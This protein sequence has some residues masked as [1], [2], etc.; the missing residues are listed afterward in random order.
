MDPVFDL[1]VLLALL[2]MLYGVLGLL[3]GCCERSGLLKRWLARMNRR[4]VM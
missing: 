2:S 3:A 1:L 4:A